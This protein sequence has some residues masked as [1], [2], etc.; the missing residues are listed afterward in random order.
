M[1]KSIYK[2]LTVVILIV[3]VFVSCTPPIVEPNFNEFPKPNAGSDIAITLPLDSVILNANA[4][5]DPDGSITNYAWSKISGPA[6][7]NIA[8]PATVQTQATRLIQ[9][10]YQFELKVTDDKGLSA[11]DTVSVTVNPVVHVNRPPVADAGPNQMINYFPASSIYLDGRGSSDPDNNLSTYAWVKITGPAFFNILTP[12]T[13]I[14][15]ITGLTGGLY[16][17]ELT[18]TDS[19]GLFAKDTVNI[20]SNRP[21]V[22]NAGANQLINFPSNSSHLDG[23]NSNDPDNN[24]ASYAWVKIAGPASYNIQNPSV[25]LTQITTLTYGG[26][27]L[28]ELTVTDSLGLFTKDTVTI[29]SNRPPVA[30]AGSNQAILLPANSVNLDA[31]NSSDP[32]NNLTTYTWTK[33]FGPLAF[34][35]QNTTSSQTQVNNLAEGDYTFSLEVTDV[36]GLTS[37][38]DVNVRVDTII[39]ASIIMINNL[40][41]SNDCNFSVN[42][43]G[44]YIPAGQNFKIYVRWIDATGSNTSN[45]VYVRR[46]NTGSTSELFNYEIANGNLIIN[47]QNLDCGFDDAQSYTVGIVL[48]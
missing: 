15:L 48:L 14:T 26:L 35:I 39:P 47:A 25:A 38:S 28:F 43:I 44:S 46:I 21:P 13:A 31:S 6:S 22:A 37:T 2:N 41:W 24:L 3:M 30:D 7:F 42:N 36:G 34:N 9:G 1:K 32:D 40:R 19:M 29:H 27:Y 23:R 33:K 12:S 5:T 20:H 11:K 17:F 8:N 4:S 18:V 45:W 16:Q 10:I